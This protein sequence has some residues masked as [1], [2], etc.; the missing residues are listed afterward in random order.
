MSQ[1][2]VMVGIK[3][4][5]PGMFEIVITSKVSYKVVRL[6]LLSCMICTKKN[7]ISGIIIVIEKSDDVI[8]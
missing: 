5:T 2:G 8:E 3:K 6:S 7:T 1:W 4:E